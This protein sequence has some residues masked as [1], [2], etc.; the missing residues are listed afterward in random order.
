MFLQ[1]EEYGNIR[2]WYIQK[3]PRTLLLQIKMHF[4]KFPIESGVHTPTTHARALPETSPLSSESH[5]SVKR[6]R[7]R[8]MCALG[9]F[10]CWR[11]YSA[12]NGELIKWIAYKVDGT[13]LRCDILEW[14][15]LSWS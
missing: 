12:F 10:L 13:F 2:E 11:M 9:V 14:T 5:V 8:A 1:L 6:I 3:Y 7:G 4:I 15:L